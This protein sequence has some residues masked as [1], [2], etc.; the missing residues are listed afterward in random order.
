MREFRWRLG[1][2]TLKVAALM[3]GKQAVAL[4]PLDKNK[5]TPQRVHIDFAKI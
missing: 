2:S 5:I 4:Y 1:R 3:R